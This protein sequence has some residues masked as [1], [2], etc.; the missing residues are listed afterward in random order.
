M[1]HAEV[2]RPQAALPIQTLDLVHHAEDELIKRVHPE[3]PTS[4]HLFEALGLPE[5]P[6]EITCLDTVMASH[7][8]M[9]DVVVGRVLDW[10]IGPGLREMAVKN[11]FAHHQRIELILVESK[12][13]ME[14]DKD[15]VVEKFNSPTVLHVQDV[16][17]LSEEDPTQRSEEMVIH[18]S[19]RRNAFLPDMGRSILLNRVKGVVEK[20]AKTPRT[21]L[22]FK[23]AATKV[24]IHGKL[25]D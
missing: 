4:D 6:L 23:L 1:K 11:L 16:T 22:D 5:R 19:Q 3:N 18:H 10:V 24:V 2:L 7:R 9:G 15:N 13:K 12:E 25:S 8:V 20:D 17:G 21:V 14:I